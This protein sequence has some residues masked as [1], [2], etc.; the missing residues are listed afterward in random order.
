MKKKNF[1][2]LYNN[3]ICKYKT[4]LE[5]ICDSLG[6]K[7]IT[8]NE[9][10]AKKIFYYYEKKRQYIKRYFMKDVCLPID[11]HKIGAIMMYA[12]L[13]S[14]PF[15]INKTKA[16]LPNQLLMANEYLA[17]Y[18]AL[19]IVDSFKLEYLR[20]TDS[21]VLEYILHLPTTYHDESTSES[22]EQYIDNVCKALYYIKDKNHFDIFAYADIL[23]LIEKYSDLSSRKQN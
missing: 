21:S 23:F 18:T 14:C 22:E 15:K 16:Q 19:S 7:S 9:R 11:R 1:D 2:V 8:F 10:R 20:E 12:I 13:K 17:F 6:I 5:T 3:V 4:D